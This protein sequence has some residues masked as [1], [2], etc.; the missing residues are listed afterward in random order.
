MSTILLMPTILFHLAQ[1]LLTSSGSNIVL[2]F[3]ANME[4]DYTKKLKYRKKSKSYIS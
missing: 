3:Q 4:I 1:A 2:R